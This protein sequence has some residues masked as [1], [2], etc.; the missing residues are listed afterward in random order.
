LIFTDPGSF[1]VA[2]VVS[3]SRRCGTSVPPMVVVVVV[4]GGPREAVPEL[5]SQRALALW[6]GEAAPASPRRP[7]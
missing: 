2:C 5:Q 6:E 7:P 4:Q 1:S 3:S